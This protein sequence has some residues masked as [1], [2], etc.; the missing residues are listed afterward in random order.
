MPIISKHA[1]IQSMLCQSKPVTRSSYL[2]MKSPHS[3]IFPS[4]YSSS[5][6]DHTSSSSF[7]FS[8]FNILPSFQEDTIA[9]HLSFCSL[10][11]I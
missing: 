6:R 1:I 7:T 11:L 2:Y 4:Q 9:S 8:S 10:G 3:L 5:V